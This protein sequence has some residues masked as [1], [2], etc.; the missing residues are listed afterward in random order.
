M[1][2]IVFS[3][4]ALGGLKCA[5]SYGKGRY[6]GGAVSVILHY[7][8]GRQATPAEL[9]EAQK[10]AEAEERRRWEAA[11]PMEGDPGDVYGF[12]LL[13]SAGSIGGEDFWKDRRETLNRLYS[14]FPS[15]E[16]DREWEELPDRGKAALAAILERAGRGEAL[17]LWY[18]DFPEERCG[19]CWLLAQVGGLSRHGDIFLVKLPDWEQGAE[20]NTVLRHSSWGEVEPGGGVPISPWHKRPPPSSPGPWGWSGAAWR[21]RTPRCGR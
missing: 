10:R 18:S 8:D 16:G 6:I 1:T 2:E 9:E 11:V 14:C 15:P 13:L 4:S 17:R 3:D 5:L 12:S 20:E 21:R 7:E 19:L